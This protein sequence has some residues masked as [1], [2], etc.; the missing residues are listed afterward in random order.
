MTLCESTAIIINL[1]D[2]EFPAEAEDFGISWFYLRRE[3]STET[4]AKPE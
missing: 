4:R 1:E 3:F 2:S